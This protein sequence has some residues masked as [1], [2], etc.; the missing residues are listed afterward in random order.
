MKHCK[1]AIIAI[2][3]ALAALALT[4]SGCSIEGEVKE[5]HDPS[6][7]IVVEKGEEFAI[8]LES[9]PTTGY[10][11]KLNH[12]LDEKILTLEK[13]EFEAPEEDLLGAPG[14]EKWTFK[15]HELGRTT[16][17]L[18]YVRPWEEEAEEPARVEEESEEESEEEGSEGEAHVE[19]EAAATEGE[20][21]IM[22]SPGEGEGPKVV[23]FNVWVKKKGSAD[24]EPKEYDDPE[25]PVEVEEGLEFSLVL[26]S[27][28]TTGY[29]WQLAEPLDEEL[30]RLVGTSFEAKGGSHGEGEEIV[31]APGEEVWTFEALKAGKTEVALEYVRPWEK[32]VKPE[33]TVTF[34][35]EIKKAGEEGSEGGH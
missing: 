23:T 26:E 13:T 27:N 4:A 20:Q 16:I 1:T 2:F 18:A 25:A 21:V 32:D 15:A 28:P 9:N 14:E 33:K 3:V 17:E 24:K 6:V 7:E 30:L 35:V 10:Q 31:G 22:P 8:V 12:P 29:S 11:W 34:E 19:G 5:F